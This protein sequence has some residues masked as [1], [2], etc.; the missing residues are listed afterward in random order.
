MFASRK[1]ARSSQPLESQSPSSY[2]NLTL[3][4]PLSLPKPLSFGFLGLRT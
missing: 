3:N 2:P 1:P 4:T